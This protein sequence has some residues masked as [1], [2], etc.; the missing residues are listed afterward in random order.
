[1][2]TLNKTQLQKVLEKKR[3]EETEKINSGLYK[4]VREGKTSKL[5]FCG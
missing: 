5:V 1:M 2:S 4:W 3:A